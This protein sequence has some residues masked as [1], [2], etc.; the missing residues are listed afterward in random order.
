MRPPDEF[1]DS[2]EQR[3]IEATEESI[4]LSRSSQE[5]T[6]HFPIVMILLRYC[7]LGYNRNKYMLMMFLYFKT[8]QMVFVLFS[9]VRLKNS[10]SESL[11]GYSVLRFND[12]KRRILLLDHS[13]RA[14][15]TAKQVTLHLN[16]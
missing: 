12:A 10:S 6:N 5:R 2:L 4:K 14:L 8:S 16:V 7:K 15:S 9:D 11:L 1:R 3:K 13:D